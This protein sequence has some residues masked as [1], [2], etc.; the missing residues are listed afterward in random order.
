MESKRKCSPGSKVKVA[1]KRSRPWEVEGDR[2]W[3]FPYQE[4]VD[5]NK[6]LI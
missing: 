1:E 4:S 2:V 6:P 3:S 5:I